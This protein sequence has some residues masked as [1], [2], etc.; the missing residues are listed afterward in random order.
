MENGTSPQTGKDELDLKLNSVPA[1]TVK[2]TSASSKH[3]ELEHETKKSD[4]KMKND[5]T[6][7]L[8]SSSPKLLS[9]PSDLKLTPTFHRKSSPLLS[10]H[11]HKRTKSADKVS[12]GFKK[13]S[14]AAD[15]SD[16]VRYVV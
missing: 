2:P 9:K 4:L 5:M 6:S 10:R 15:L 12:T 7:S 14:S 13:V 1:R 8:S 11:K 3:A 16:S